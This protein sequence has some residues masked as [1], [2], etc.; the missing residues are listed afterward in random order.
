MMVRALHGKGNVAMMLG[1]LGTTPEGG[2]HRG[3]KERFS[4]KTVAS[5]SSLLSSIPGKTPRAWRTRKTC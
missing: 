4:L 5:T 2:A 3:H 1:E